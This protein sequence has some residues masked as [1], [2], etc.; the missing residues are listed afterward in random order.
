MLYMA[1]EIVPE[2][3]KA[4]WKSHDIVEELSELIVQSLKG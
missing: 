1:S 2:K 3:E 4:T